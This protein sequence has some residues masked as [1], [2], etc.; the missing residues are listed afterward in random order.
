M[1]Q[2]SGGTSDSS[3]IDIIG[4]ILIASL[5][6]RCQFL[7]FTLESLDV[8]ITIIATEPGEMLTLN[9]GNIERGLEDDFIGL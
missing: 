6:R 2:L 3:V 7:V 8:G 4:S 5:S 9:T 1:L